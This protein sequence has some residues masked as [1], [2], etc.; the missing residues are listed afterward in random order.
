[1]KWLCNC[2][3]WLMPSKPA[4]LV[5]LLASCLVAHPS[6]A[7]VFTSDTTIDENDATYDGEDIVISDATVVIDG[8]HTFNSLLLT[9]NAVLT[10]S[11]CTTTNTHRLDLTVANAIVVSANS[12]V[13]VSMRGYRGNYTTGNTTVGGARAGC[14]GSYGGFGGGAL[15]SVAYGDYAL[16]D[17]WG[18][19][20]ANFSTGGGRMKGVAERLHLD[21]VL[22][23]NGAPGADGGAGG[24]IL[25]VVTKLTGSGRIQAWGGMGGIDNFGSGGGGRIAVYASDFS[26][27]PL[28]NITASGGAGG[29]GGDGFRWIAGGAGTVYLR[30]RDEPLGTLLIDGG[31]YGTPLGLAGT[32]WTR[33][34]DFVVIRGARVRPISET[35]V[36]EFGTNLTVSGGAQLTLVGSNTV[37]HAPMTISNS[38][39]EVSGQF[40]LTVPLTV[41]EGSRL[42]VTTLTA[43]Q[44]LALSG[45]TVVTESLAVPG[46]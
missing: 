23:A 28:T 5:L 16:P 42:T 24:G 6:A 4:S 26:S 39:L 19:G 29:P 38:Q 37:L 14:G 10:H 40:D 3:F 30:D 32:N 20:G 44:P 18:S 22:W 25:L 9:N 34:P 27:F 43:S 36:L 13:D 17:D 11:P 45:A 21:G 1:M 31:G 8:L 15:S 41:T 35:A 2:G 7:A 46:L 33:F 12:R